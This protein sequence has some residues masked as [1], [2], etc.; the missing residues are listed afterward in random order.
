MASWINHLSHPVQTSCTLQTHPFP[1]Q[2]CRSG[3]WILDRTWDDD[4]YRLMGYFWTQQY[5]SQI[6][7][8]GY[9]WR[10]RMSRECW[11]RI[12]LVEVYYGPTDNVCCPSALEQDVWTGLWMVQNVSQLYQ[13]LEPQT[14]MATITAD[15]SSTSHCRTLQLKLFCH[16]GCTE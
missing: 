11:K 1:K 3:S 2:T 7:R 9:R 15:V 12:R 14:Y 10:G 4:W 6:P 16:E 8:N 5:G 13:Y